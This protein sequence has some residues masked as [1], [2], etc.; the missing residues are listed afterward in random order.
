MINGWALLEWPRVCGTP[1]VSV[2]GPLI[3]R[4][5]ACHSP[6]SPHPWPARG[7]HLVSSI[8]PT[9]QVTDSLLLVA[10][11]V[12]LKQQLTL[13]FCFFFPLH[14]EVQFLLVWRLQEIG[15]PVLMIFIPSPFYDSF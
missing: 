13:F 8:K 2:L 9:Q 6:P 7:T 5:I 4:V 1:Q 12:N 15:V 11:F 3:L 10:G 14:V